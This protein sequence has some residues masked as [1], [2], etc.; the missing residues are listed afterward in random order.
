MLWA[1]SSNSNGTIVKKL[2][3]IN[4]GTTDVLSQMY[5]NQGNV[6]FSSRTAQ[7]LWECNSGPCGDQVSFSVG[8]PN[9]G[10]LT[11]S[12]FTLG[13]GVALIN[14]YSYT[15]NTGGYA[16]P[17]VATSSVF[18]VTPGDSLTVSWVAKDVSG[19]TGDYAYIILRQGGTNYYLQGDGTFS[20]SVSSRFAYPQPAI[21]KQYR[22]EA[23]FVVPASFTTG[24][25]QVLIEPTSSTVT[26]ATQVLQV[27]DFHLY[28][29][30]G[31]ALGGSANCSSTTAPAVCG[32]AAAGSVN[33][34]VGATSVAVNTTAVTANSQI[35]PIFDSSLGTKLGVTCNTTFAQPYVSARVAGTSFT[36]TVPTAPTTNPA[37]FS[38]SITN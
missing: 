11:P 36:V 31:I 20:S 7:G 17:V 30:N 2:K 3:S 32:I 8:I 21:G 24:T 23:N 9:G 5:P 37:C 12:Q 18:K 25:A 35:V 14:G 6:G 26:N 15:P 16:I 34:A 33:I 29:G 1:D 10:T 22:F 27:G 4:A 28:F 13:S 38:Y 19:F